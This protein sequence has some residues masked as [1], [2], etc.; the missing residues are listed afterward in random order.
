[1]CGIVLVVG[2]GLSISGEA[3]ARPCL[4]IAGACRVL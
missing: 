1:M 3:R 4:V 2:T